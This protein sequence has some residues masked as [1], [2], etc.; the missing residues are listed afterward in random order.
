MAKILVVEDEPTTR[1]LVVELLENEGYSV[2]S[3]GD[4]R[5]ALDLLTISEFDVIIADWGLPDV[6]GIELCRQVRRSG[7]L[8]GIL[9]LTGRS[10]V[11][12]KENGLDSGADDYVTK[13]FEERELLARVRALLRRGKAVLDDS[14]TIGDIEIQLRS[15]R[16]TRGGKLVDL[17]P[18]E[19]ALLD[20]LLR[21]RGATFSL[22]ALIRRV[23]SS[24]EFI[25]RDAVRQC[26]RRIRQKLDRDGD[27]SII[28]TV[29]GIGYKI[30]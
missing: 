22:D 16:I 25:T 21:N 4:G 12:H 3:A 17:N 28:T 2:E 23:W 14:Y 18:K 15:R 24:E 26:V 6:S 27:D 9:M 10:A 30:E 20:F 29:T 7:S 13:P 1:E 8:C 19:F 11:H 5:S